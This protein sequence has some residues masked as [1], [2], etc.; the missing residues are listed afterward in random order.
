VGHPE[1]ADAAAA[2]AASGRRV[3][4]FVVMAVVVAGLTVAAVV[5]MRL[6]GRAPEAER[7]APAGP[8]GILVA[9]PT[10]GAPVAPGTAAAPAASA[11][12]PAPAERPAAA[13]TPSDEASARLRPNIRRGPMA[14]PQTAAMPGVQFPARLPGRKLPPRGGW[15]AGAAPNR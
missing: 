12:T 7:V 14:R 1:P 13:T 4:G 15:P 8:A 10:A 2:K 9:P 6:E 11:A 5:W 3:A